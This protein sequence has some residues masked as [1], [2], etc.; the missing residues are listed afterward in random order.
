MLKVIQKKDIEEIRVQEKSLMPEGFGNNMKIQE[1]RDL[2]RYVMAN[3]F[4]T[5]VEVQSGTR[6]SGRSWACPAGFRFRTARMRWSF[7]AMVTA[8]EAMKTK[9]FVGSHNDFQVKLN[10][11]LM[12]GKERVGIAAQP[13]Q[14]GIDVDLVKGENAIEIRIKSTGNR[15]AILFAFARSR[16]EVCGYPEPKKK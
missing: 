3:P 16:S 4:I 5:E 1:F 14:V 6:R 11:S 2:V 10:G 9:L 7:G 13:D 15:E 8:P 12:E